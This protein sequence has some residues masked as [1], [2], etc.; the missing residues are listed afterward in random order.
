MRLDDTVSMLSNI[1]RN[2]DLSPSIVTE[3]ANEINQAD[4]VYTTVIQQ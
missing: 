1:E 2:S 3:M 4:R